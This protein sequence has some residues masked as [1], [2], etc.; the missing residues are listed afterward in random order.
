MA[1]VSSGIIFLKEKKKKERKKE[2]ILE[3]VS[4]ESTIPTNDLPV[5]VFISFFFLFY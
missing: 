4:N 2:L 5:I 1:A 3:Y